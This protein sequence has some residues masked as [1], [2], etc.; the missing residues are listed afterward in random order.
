MA[1]TDMESWTLTAPPVCVTIGA[2]MVPVG[3][4]S[5]VVSASAPSAAQLLARVRVH[6]WAS[7]LLGVDVSLWANV[8]VLL[9]LVTWAVAIQSVTQSL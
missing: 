1:K 7:Y 5:P 4:W 8:A 2:L 6:R 9:T 3:V